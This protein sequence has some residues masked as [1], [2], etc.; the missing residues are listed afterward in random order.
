M[1]DMVRLIRET[2]RPA[3]GC[4][5]PGAVA[6]AVAAA[7]QATSG[8]NPNGSAGLFRRIAPADVRDVSV[9][10]SRN[11]F[12]NCFSIAIPNSERH[13]GIRMAAALGAFCNPRHEL[14]LF[15]DLQ[16]EDVRA[17]ERLVAAKA[18]RAEVRPSESA[19]LAIEAAVTVHTQGGA[20]VGRC[21]IRGG[22]ANIVWLKR[23]A[24]QTYCGSSVTEHTTPNGELTE[25][26]Q[27]TIAELMAAVDV[28]PAEAL[29]PV[30]QA[31]ELNG[32]AYE[33]GLAQP[34]GLGAGFYGPA[35]G[36]A[37]PD[38]AAVVMRM[39]AAASDARMS[40]YPLPVMTSAGSG[41]QG[42]V[43]TVPVLGFAR[44]GGVDAA[45]TLRAVAFSH[46]VTLKLAL[47]IGYLSALCG[48]AVKAGVGAACGI[49]YAMGGTA[50]DAE[51]AVK[52]MAA[53]LTGMICDGAK[54]GCALKVGTAAGMAVRA[55]QLAM[56]KVAITDDNGIVGATVE[57]T[58]RHLADLSASMGAVDHKIVEIME[59]KLARI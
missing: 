55:A 37:S 28:L 56:Q 26:K 3:L 43:A 12:K 36:G 41:N 1:P 58:I 53:T 45:R 7:A 23:G 21:L 6:L 44:R 27:M 51:R 13:K 18:V 31:L 34:L 30:Q 29:Y 33:A 16:P 10:V 35:D 48:V 32:A 59:Q 22:H 9:F 20:L 42:I 2:L 17:A 57:E 38:I 11:I 15:C 24:E 19:E 46:L 14:R 8:W 4:T 5:E 25:L 52:V 39:A 49:V 50:E 47:H 54:A 40:G